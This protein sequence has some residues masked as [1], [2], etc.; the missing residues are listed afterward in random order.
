MLVNVR[1]T[2]ARILA[3][4]EE[5]SEIIDLT[6]ASKHQ[7]S[8]I[9]E[10]G[11]YTALLSASITYK[12]LLG[13]NVGCY[14]PREYMMYAAPYSTEDEVV[15]IITRGSPIP[16]RVTEV[17]KTCGLMGL[18][19]I[20]VILN[21]ISDEDEE[22]L[23]GYTKFLIET[24]IDDD[25]LAVNHYIAES[26]LLTLIAVEAALKGESKERARGILEEL[27]NIPI[28][29]EPNTKFLIENCIQSRRCILFS[30]SPLHGLALKICRDLN[31]N[32][33]VNMKACKVDEHPY[34]TRTI[35]EED[36]VIIMKTELE[37]RSAREISNYLRI[38]G[39]NSKVI[40][41]KGDPLMAG[42]IMGCKILP[43]LYEVIPEITVED[44]W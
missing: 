23:S 25:K 9:A 11:G 8:L 13:V 44:V 6:S 31:L 10:G 33:K 20:L 24:G 14:F 17:V 2:I 1:K 21:R 27:K 28:K 34:I 15:Y 16:P 18:R 7:L 38:R 43:Q 42:I 35:T 5:L 39:L 37:D 30:G 22:E 32:L 29:E 19:T 4:R 26:T 3:L 41:Y 36:Y 40:E 12:S